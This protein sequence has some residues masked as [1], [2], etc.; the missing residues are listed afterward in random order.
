MRQNREKGEIESRWPVVQRMCQKKN[1]CLAI[2]VHV[3]HGSNWIVGIDG[4][5]VGRWLDVRRHGRH[6]FHGRH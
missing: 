3:S 1:T 4:Y 6:G 5:I 2:S